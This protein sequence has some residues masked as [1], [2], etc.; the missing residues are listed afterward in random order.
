MFE[1]FQDFFF[2][3]ARGSGW[4]YTLPQVEK[5]HELTTI[6]VSIKIKPEV[7]Y[8]PAFN[9]VKWT[10]ILQYLSTQNGQILEFWGNL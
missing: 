5:F 7:I 3:G 8:H 2:N 1:S 6:C 4:W 9:G 10:W